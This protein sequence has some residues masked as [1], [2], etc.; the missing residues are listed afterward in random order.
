MRKTIGFA[1]K[2]KASGTCTGHPCD[3]AEVPTLPIGQHHPES[4]LSPTLPGP[5]TCLPGGAGQ[6]LRTCISHKLQ[7]RLMLWIRG[8]TLKTNSHPR[9]N[10][11]QVLRRVHVISSDSTAPAK[12]FHTVQLM[13]CLCLLLD[14]K[15][16]ALW[17][18]CILGSLETPPR[19]GLTPSQS[20]QDRGWGVGRPQ[21]LESFPSDPKPSQDGEWLQM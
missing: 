12:L 7:V 9:P 1:R 2:F 4:L 6:S 17:L 19:T 8:H 10:S 18:V 11:S 14:W 13:K 21:S 3:S 16:G 20:A 15:P 5:R